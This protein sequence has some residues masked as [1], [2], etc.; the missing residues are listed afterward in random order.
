MTIIPTSMKFILRALVYYFLSIYIIPLLIVLLINFIEI[1]I[2]DT[3]ITIYRFEGY[4]SIIISLT[5]ILIIGKHFAN[6]KVAFV[7]LIYC[8][9]VIFIIN[10]FGLI[11]SFSVS[12]L[13]HDLLIV[14]MMILG[15]FL[16]SATSRLTSL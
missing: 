8:G 1:L 7:S 9:V 11:S 13:F 14:P 3:L 4:F 5:T 16:K 10:L 6:A 15:Y 12:N 2:N